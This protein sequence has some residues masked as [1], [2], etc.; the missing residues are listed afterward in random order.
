MRAI[1][2]AFAFAVSSL[3]LVACAASP[4]AAEATGE[5]SQAS[6][7][8]GAVGTTCTTDAACKSSLVCEPICPVIPGRAHCEIAGGTCEVAC[9]RTSTSLSGST[10]TSADG[11]H[12]I[13]FSSATAFS[14]TDGCPNTGIHCENVALMTGTYTSNGT[15]ITLT[16]TFG[17]K[18][19]LTVESHCYEGLLDK[20]TGADLYP[21]N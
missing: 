16:S 9:T 13:T 11:A 20:T 6:S 8:G 15:T 14:K 1:K 19:T 17:T 5:T 2:S 10:F 4:G 21:T 12:S 7:R 3:L 18:D